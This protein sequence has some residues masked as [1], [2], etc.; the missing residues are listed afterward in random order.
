M[1]S[2]PRPWIRD[3]HIPTL[4]LD[5]TRPHPNARELIQGAPPPLN[6]C[7]SNF[8][9][10]FTCCLRSVHLARSTLLERLVSGDFTFS[11]NE[12]HR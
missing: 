12:I 4:W 9:Q 11:R 1:A 5:M 7:K 8:D 2:F 10:K 3:S 6:L